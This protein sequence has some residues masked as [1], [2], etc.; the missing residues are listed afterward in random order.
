MAT[1]YAST[2]TNTA[3]RIEFI[4]NHF[5]CAL[6]RLTNLNKEETEK[7]L[8]GIRN[9]EIE[10]LTFIGYHYS[11]HENIVQVKIILRLDW[12]EHHKLRSQKP[13][14]TYK[15]NFDEGTSPEIYG[16]IQTAQDTIERENLI[17][18]MFYGYAPTIWRNTQ[19]LAYVREKYG[20]S[21]NRTI[22]N[23]SQLSQVEKSNSPEAPELSAECHL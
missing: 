7:I 2:V 16:L 1:T 21:P 10:S 12:D 20:T 4:L 17:S 19:K 8:D 14:I 18:T 13:I 15:N 3:T 5:R 22:Y 11:N 9:E 23:Y 6:R